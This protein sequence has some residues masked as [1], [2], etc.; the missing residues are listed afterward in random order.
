MLKAELRKIYLTRQRKLSHAEHTERSGRIAA[1][2]FENFDL[3]NVRFLHCFLPIEKNKEVDTWLI[4]QDVWQRFPDIKTVVS[5]VDFEKMTLENIA[6]SSET[7]LIFNRWHILEPEGEE[8]VGA[9]MIDVILVPLLAV[10]ERGFRVG[11]GRGFY[12]KFLGECR[13]DALKIGLSYFP[14]VERISDVR[15]FDVKLDFCVTPAEVLDFKNQ[16]YVR[17]PSSV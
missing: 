4:F 5:R 10:D 6:F 9:K 16:F 17:E 14:P 7:K 12:D 13:R 3:K 11:Y 15:E 2:F 1:R 8:T